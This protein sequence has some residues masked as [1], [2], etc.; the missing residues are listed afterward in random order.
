MKLKTSFYKGKNPN[1]GRIY[2]PEVI[3]IFEN[4]LN[5]LIRKN[6]CV[7]EDDNNDDFSPKINVEN[8]IGFIT[9]YEWD[10]DQRLIIE[11]YEVEKFTFLLLESTQPQAY[12]VARV[13][14]NGEISPQDFRFIKFGVKL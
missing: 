10:K 8:I 9:D 3:E 5:D 14:D 2:S 13:W 4:Q 1:T 11:I 6:F 7:L 12:I